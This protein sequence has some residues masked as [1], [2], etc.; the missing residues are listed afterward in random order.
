MLSNVLKFINVFLN[1][2]ECI[3]KEIHDDFESLTS[4]T[5]MDDNPLNSRALT[6][7]RVR[8]FSLSSV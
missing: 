4:K 3:L 1:N 5:K 7:F 6:F 8:G 2:L